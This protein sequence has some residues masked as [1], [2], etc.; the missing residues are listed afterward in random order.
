M[1]N[2]KRDPAARKTANNIG[3]RN[4]KRGN[5]GDGRGGI[6]GEVNEREK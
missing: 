5:L 6:E 3:Y 1:K 4:E 2:K